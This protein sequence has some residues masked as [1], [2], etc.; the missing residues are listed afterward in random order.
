VLA[1]VVRR[2]RHLR[3]E[4]LVRLGLRHGACRP[5][6]A[7]DGLVRIGEIPV[8][9]AVH[10]ADVEAA[11]SVPQRR[12]GEVDDRV[13]TRDLP[14]TAG[15]VLRLAFRSLAPVVTRRVRRMDHAIVV[16]AALHQPPDLVEEVDAEAAMVDGQALR[17]SAGVQ[18]ER[19][20]FSRYCWW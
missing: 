11:T 9:E 8:A 2:N 4:L 6:R 20:R 3:C 14:L 17:A 18:L 16:L 10:L 7:R 5:V 12:L 1:V 19:P 13:H 15:E